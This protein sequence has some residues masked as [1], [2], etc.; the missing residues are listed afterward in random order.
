MNLR[1]KRAISH[2]KADNRFLARVDVPLPD[3]SH[4]RNGGGDRLLQQELHAPLHGLNCWAGMDIIG[5]GDDQAVQVERFNHL[6]AG[7]KQ[8]RLS[9]SEQTGGDARVVLVGISDGRKNKW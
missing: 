6:L 7:S 1:I 3:L 4:V 2:A 8:N 9:A 5:A